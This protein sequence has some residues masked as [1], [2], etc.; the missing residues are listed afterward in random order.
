MRA[1]IFSGLALAALGAV[2]NGQIIASD[3]MS[4]AGALTANGWV[5]HSGA[6]NKVINSDGNVATLDFSGGSG[7][8]INLA[9][10][11]PQG[12]ADTTYFSF[13]LNVPSG[14]PVNP[15]GNG[16]YFMHLKDA[17]FFYH[18]RIGLLS[19]A[20]A[21]DFGIG[22]SNTS[23]I[24]GSGGVWGADLSFDTNYNVVASWDATT[25]TATL[26][27]DPTGM[28]DTSAQSVGTFFGDPMEAIALRQS[29]DHTGFITIDNIVVG[30]TFGDVSGGGGPSDNTGAAGCDGST[31]QCPCFAVGAVDAGC[32]NSGSANGAALVATGNAA[33]SSD[34]FSLAVSGAALSKPGLVLSGTADLSPGLNN[35][36]DS[37]GLLCVG[38]TTQRGAVVFTDAS[39]AASLPDFQG[40]AYGLAGNVT[41]GALSTYQYWFR[42]PNTACAPNDGPAGD[43]NFSNLWAVTWMP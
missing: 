40:S 33:L 39:G 22:I 36:A 18:A 31:G 11:A 41:A 29:N 19:P 42:D 15:D 38:G 10:S 26:W 28:G 30:K 21:G 2:A 1:A 13:T 4:I 27:I 24:G 6:G 8:D 35:I 14:N 25:D 43:F 7:E 16:S 12:P 9:F 23:N 3:D 34:T 5:A 32:P 37:A 17:G 20:A